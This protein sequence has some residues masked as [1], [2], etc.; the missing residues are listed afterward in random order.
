[1]ISNFFLKKQS[2]FI[3]LCKNFFQSLCTFWE[4]RFQF[5]FTGCFII[6]SNEN[7]FLC[8]KGIS[9]YQYLS[10]SMS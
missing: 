1:M 4:I 10:I 5:V 9:L 3:T 2:T 7:V 8:V 6:F